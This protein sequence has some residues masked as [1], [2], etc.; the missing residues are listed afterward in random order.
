MVWLI[1]AVNGK[2]MASFAGHEDEVN[3]AYFTK[4]DKG[5]HI[6]S[7]SADQ[8]IRVWSPL[9][10]DCVQTVRGKGG[11]AVFHT[12][13]ILCLALHHE[14]PLALSGDAAGNVFAS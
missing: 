6:V 8:T 5:K 9:Q 2:V 7:A 12:G 3:C 11:K 13:S 1:N 10:A 4:D 14:K